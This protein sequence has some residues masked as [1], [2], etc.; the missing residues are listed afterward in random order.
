MVL[1]KLFAIATSTAL[2]LFQFNE[3][4]FPLDQLVLRG[5]S[6]EVSKTSRDVL[7]SLNE[8]SQSK[9][10]GYFLVSKPSLCIHLFSHFNCRLGN[11]NLNL[12]ISWM[13]YSTSTKLL[14]STSLFESWKNNEKEKTLFRWSYADRFECL[15]GESVNCIHSANFSS[16][17]NFCPGLISISFT[18]WFVESW[19]LRKWKMDLKKFIEKLALRSFFAT[20]SS[21]LHKRRSHTHR[22]QSWCNWGFTELIRWQHKSSVV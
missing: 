17:N 4:T 14:S 16:M 10:Q 15:E 7:S 19:H 11:R 13:Y 21:L 12:A 3:N 9:T 22:F 2:Q 8:R 1:V 20:S 18:T 6:S 5:S